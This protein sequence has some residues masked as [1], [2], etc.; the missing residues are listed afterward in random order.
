MISKEALHK[1][2]PQE[3]TG[4]LYE[5]CLTN[6]EDAQVAVKNKDYVK[7]NGHLQ[8]A[9]DIVHRLGAGINYEAGIIADQLDAVYNYMADR[10]VEANITKDAA[11]IDDV[12]RHLETIT[13]AWQEAMK[14]NQDKQTK[15]V[16]QKVNLYEQ[17]SM[18][19]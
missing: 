9:G 11:I 14:E 8:K 6:L 18:Y 13:S 7:A 4:L 17:N 16:K 19:E 2:S 5:A 15:E 1:K 10:I 3:I 12:I